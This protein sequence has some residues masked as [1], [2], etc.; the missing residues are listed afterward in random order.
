MTADGKVLLILNDA[1][2][3]R[4][5]SDRLAAEGLQCFS[6][7]DGITGLALVTEQKPD[8]VVCS[9]SLPKMNGLEVCR[10]IK[11]NHKLK[12]VALLIVL[13]EGDDGS[14]VS[15]LEVG[16]NDYL[17]R[18]LHLAEL[19]A[20]VRSHFKNRTSITR[21]KDDNKELA[22]ILEIAEMLTSTLNS[23]DLFYII[24]HKVAEALAVDQ[25]SLIRIEPGSRRGHVEASMDPDDADRPEVVLADLPEVSRCLEANKMLYV[26]DAR[27]DPELARAHHADELLSVLA[28]PLQLRQSTAHRIVFRMARRGEPLTYREIKFCQIATT[29]AAN[30]LENAYLFESLEIAHATLTDV[31]KR[32]PLTQIYN[33]GHL[34]ERLEAEFGRSLRKRTPLACLLLDVDH[35]KRINDELGHQAG[36]AVLVGLGRVLKEAVRGHDFVGRY[37]GEEFMAVLP[38]TDA[39]GALMVAERIRSELRRVRYEGIDDRQV[40]VSVGV[41]VLDPETEGPAGV[42]GLVAAADEA[43]YAAKHGGRDRVVVQ[44]KALPVPATGND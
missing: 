9:R 25:C 16:A 10:L 7:H 2:E 4:T 31:A 34:F 11:R 36:D 19:T 23:C 30:A 26:E 39:Q 37:G 28:V 35:F 14:I 43:L 22:T 21:L 20:A 44:E 41:S 33:R 6:A 8:V 38:E 18:P 42:A 13:D 12:H 3:A 29:V 17:L 5:I 15:S 40:T 27:R 32:D 24:V 1:S